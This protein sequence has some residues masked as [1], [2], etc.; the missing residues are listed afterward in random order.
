M[1]TERDTSSE[2]H[3][4]IDLKKIFVE[5]RP[6]IYEARSRPVLT[7][8]YKRAGYLIT[9]SH[10]PS[11]QTKFGDETS[12]LRTL[13]EDEFVTTVRKINRRAEQVGAEPDYDET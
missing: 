7:E 12:A 10:A 11:W 13:A 5:I 6:N 9:L 8:L 4:K 3:N 2:V 1:A